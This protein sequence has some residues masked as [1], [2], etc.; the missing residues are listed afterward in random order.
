MNVTSHQQKEENEDTKK[1]KRRAG[2]KEKR[3]QATD[4]KEATCCPSAVVKG[5]T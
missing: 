1:G 2:E 5:A 4:F 3:K